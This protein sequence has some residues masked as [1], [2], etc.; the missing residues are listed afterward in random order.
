VADLIARLFH[1]HYTLRGVSYVSHRMGFCPQVPAHRAVER[2]DEGH[3][4]MTEGGVA[5]GKR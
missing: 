3:P 4:H 5:G 1:I 2:D